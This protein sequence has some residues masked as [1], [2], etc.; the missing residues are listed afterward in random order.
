M[1][2]VPANAARESAAPAYTL[3]SRA[4]HW[5][6]AILVLVMLPA[7]LAMGELGR[8]PLQD[9][10]FHL[11]TSIGALLIPIVAV[12]LLY[13]LTHVPLPLPP[14]ISAIHR[15]AAELLHWSLYAL[16]IIQ[17][18]VGWIGASAHGARIMVLWMFELPPI[19]PS[20]KS[21][22]DKMFALHGVIGLILTFTLVAHIGAALFHQ[23]VRKDHVFIRMITG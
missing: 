18:M 20:D 5:F 15:L 3:T 1:I 17:P 11:H 14:E 10:L 23:F 6:T 13:R 4:L 22:S 7:G 2:N 8:W 9:L 19:W 16:L 21:L 12:R